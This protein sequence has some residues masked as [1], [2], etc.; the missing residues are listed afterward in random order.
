MLRI[1]FKV[2]MRSICKMF[3]YFQDLVDWIQDKEEVEIVDLILRIREKLVNK[4][5]CFDHLVA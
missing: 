2:S 3:H 4:Y 1:K 5:V